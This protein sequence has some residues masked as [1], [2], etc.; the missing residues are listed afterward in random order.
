MG[1]QV[2]AMENAILDCFIEVAEKQP[3]GEDLV[4]N[5]DTAKFLAKTIRNIQAK[6]VEGACSARWVLNQLAGMKFPEQGGA[7]DF[8]KKSMISGGIKL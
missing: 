5:A 4:L 2:K 1:E 7:Y 6:E 3:D 8:V